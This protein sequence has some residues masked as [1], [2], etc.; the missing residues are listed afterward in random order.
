MAKLRRLL[1]QMVIF[2]RTFFRDKSPIVCLGTLTVDKISD[3]DGILSSIKSIS[4][5]GQSFPCHFYL[6]SDNFNFFEF[7][8]I[9]PRR[10]AKSF[11]DDASLTSTRRAGSR[12]P[13]EATEKEGRKEGM[14]DSRVLEGTPVVKARGNSTSIGNVAHGNV[15]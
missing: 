6:G 15:R 1:G 2:H 11:D 7:R 3:N 4:R 14:T 10:N 8:R 9:Y 5:I 12:F 13:E